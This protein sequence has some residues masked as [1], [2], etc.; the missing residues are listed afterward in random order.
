[1]SELRVDGKSVIV[2]GAGRGFGRSHA[3][4]LASRGAKVVV[5]DNG[6]EVD[7]SGSSREPAL[8]TVKEIEAAGGEA[9]ACFESV[10]EA[11]G[12]NAIVQ[13]ALDS[14]G[15]LDIVV[16]NAGIADPQWFDDMTE[17]QF[18]IMLET[19]YSG[20]VWVS[21]AAWPHLQKAPHGAIVN[22]ASEGIRRA[23]PE[24]SYAGAKGGAVHPR[25][26]SGRT[27]FGTSGERDCT[28]G[29][30]AYVRPACAFAGVRRAC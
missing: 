5:A 28:K 25:V 1:M 14:F 29:D 10:C 30:D 13:T 3:L 27:P 23:H 16:N 4:L 26:G 20:T 22:T 7:G 19:Q 17:E 11:A 24:V 8:Q 18:R 9:V 15:K 12:A 2:T 21:K 6:C